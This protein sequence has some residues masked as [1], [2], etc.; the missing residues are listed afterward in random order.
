MAAACPSDLKLGAQIGRGSYGSV[1]A[2]MYGDRCVAVKAVPTE[3]SAEGDALKGELQAEIK[4]LKECDSQWI[5]RYFGCLAKG[6]LL[7]I[8]MEHC[9]G[10]S[11][12]DILRAT[13]APMLEDEIAMVAAATVSGLHYLHETRQLLHRDIKAGNILLS[14]TDG[15]GVKLCDLGVSA[16][17]A[18]HT[19]R[20]TVI[21]T[22][23]WMSPEL[24]E[25]GAYGTST[26]IWSLGITLLEMAEINPPH[27]EVHP[28]PDP[29]HTNLLPTC[30]TPPPTP[31]L[32]PRPRDST[33]PPRPVGEPHPDPN[34]QTLTLAGEPH[35]PRALPHHEPPAAPPQGRGAVV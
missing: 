6:G 12:S 15:G 17:V 25:S 29:P 14:T 1:F 8:C 13:G 7:W 2:A 33:A 35:N 27:H 24:I 21:G 9:S 10:G 20:S 23:L 4:M 11:V 18:S 26:D 19:K 16:S 32:W 5:V 30:R 22:P 3:D 34:P 28:N 31:S